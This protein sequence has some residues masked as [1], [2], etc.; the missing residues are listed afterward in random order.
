MTFPRPWLLAALGAASVAVYVRWLALPMALPRYV[1]QP[2]LDVQKIL[3]ET[4][5]ATVFFL[6][7]LLVLFGLYYLG[8]SLVLEMSG[9]WLPWLV[10][11]PPA[12]SS[13]ALIFMYPVTAADLFQYIWLGRISALRGENPFIVTPNMRPDELLYPYTIF[14]NFPTVYGAG[15]IQLS[16]LLARLGGDDILLSVIIF[17]L[18]MVA[19]Y[20]LCLALVYLILRRTRPALAWAGVYVLAWN[21]LVVFNTAGDGHNDIM[22]ILLVLLALYLAQRGWWTAAATALVLSVSVKWLSLALAPVFLIVA[23][24]MIGRSAWVRVGGGL[25]I[26]LGLAALIQAPFFAGPASLVGGIPNIGSQFTASLATVVRDS[27]T[28]RVGADEAAQIARLAAFG[29]FGV[30]YIW[31]L[32]RLVGTFDSLVYGAYQVFFFYLVIA[33][34]WFQPWYVV[35]LVPLAA[36]LVGAPVVERTVIFSFTAMLVH[37]FLGFGWRLAWFGGNIP[38]LQMVTALVIV[39]P[40]LLWWITSEAR[41]PLPMLNAQ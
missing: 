11:I 6:A 41:R 12:V 4:P 22:M 37:V 39:G 9:R 35:W 38:T 24:R 10:L 13:A 27:L 17:K 3:G 33:A 7:V 15:F 25:A 36:L 32:L 16:G 1:D 5:T 14:R 28:A 21:P 2:L 40:P 8:Y 26:G 18:A 34:V 30:L 29:L 20:A 19:S 23:L 31:Q